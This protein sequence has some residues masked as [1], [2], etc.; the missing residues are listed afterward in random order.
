MLIP[1]FGSCSF[2]IVSFLLYSSGSFFICNSK[3]TSFNLF[4]ASSMVKPSISGTSTCIFISSSFSLSFFRSKYGSTSDNTWP[5]TGA[6]TAP[7]WGILGTHIFFVESIQQ[8]FV[9][10]LNWLLI[11]V[12]T[13]KL[14]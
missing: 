3:L 9:I 10:L 4:V 1:L 6:P 5:P 12:I 2:I 13:L 11:V 8:I 14:E 7:A